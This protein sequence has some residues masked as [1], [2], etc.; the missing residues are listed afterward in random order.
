MPRLL[1]YRENTES[2]RSFIV[3][4]LRSTRVAGLKRFGFRVDGVI[5]KVC[6]DGRFEAKVERQALDALGTF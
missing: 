6:V 3:N 1:K 2:K 5:D 4:W